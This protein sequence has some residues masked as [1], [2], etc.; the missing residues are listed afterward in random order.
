MKLA[1]KL[2]SGRRM[3]SR[4]ASA[5]DSASVGKSLRSMKASY[6]RAGAAPRGWTKVRLAVDAKDGGVSEKCPLLAQGAV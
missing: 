3:S 1:E 5:I 2:Q 4:W 6:G